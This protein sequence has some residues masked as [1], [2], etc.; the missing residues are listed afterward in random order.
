MAEEAEGAQQRLITVKTE[1]F[2]AQTDAA[3][4]GQRIITVKKEKLDATADAMAAAQQRDKSAVAKRKAEA[5]LET[6]AKRHRGTAERAAELA[7][8]NRRLEEEKESLALEC[9]VCADAR[10]S[11][12]YLPCKHLAVCDECDG[13]LEERGQSCPMC[14]TEVKQRH[15]KIH[16]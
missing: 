1:R 14:Q 4:A 12:L 9:C 15:G 5:D 2:D 7:A 16:F 11:V 10:P 3:A 8:A 13:Q 6:E